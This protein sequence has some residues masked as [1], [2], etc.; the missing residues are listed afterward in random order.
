MPRE[1]CDFE[2]LE[3]RNLLRGIESLQVRSACRKIGGGEGK[4]GSDIHSAGR[5][6]PRTAEPRRIRFKVN[7]EFG[8][9]RIS[10]IVDRRRRR[11][12]R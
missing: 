11:M 3:S 5:M 2:A 10:I 7:G 9:A 6:L 12:D 1:L 8:D 4:D